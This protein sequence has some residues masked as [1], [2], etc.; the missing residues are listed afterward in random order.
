MKKKR[1]IP[2]FK[3]GDLFE[4]CGYHPCICTEVNEDD[5]VGIS[6]INGQERGCSIRNCGVVKRTMEEVVEIRLHGPLDKAMRKIMEKE[7]DA[8]WIEHKIQHIKGVAPIFGCIVVTPEGTMIP[9]TFSG[10]Y[11]ESM[12]KWCH[13]EDW[14]R[15]LKD[16]YHIEKVTVVSGVISLESLAKL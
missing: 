15:W 7:G 14:S 9:T 16:G 13:P 10:N 2:E 3:V 11:G 1:E 8:W 4:D 6:L 5:I 12:G